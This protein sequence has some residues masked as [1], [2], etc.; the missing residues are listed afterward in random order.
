MADKIIL[1]RE[2]WCLCQ[3]GSDR[4]ETYEVYVR[5]VKL[6]NIYES[7]TDMA[8]E[9]WSPEQRAN[10]NLSCRALYAAMNNM[11]EI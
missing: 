10:L 6:N 1:D 2:E 9:D 4:T 8:Y 11:E 5:K 7:L 3:L